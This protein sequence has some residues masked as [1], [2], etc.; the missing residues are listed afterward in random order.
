MEFKLCHIGNELYG[1]ASILENEF[2]DKTDEK[3]V[4]RYNKKQGT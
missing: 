1:D 4:L 3:K 2:A